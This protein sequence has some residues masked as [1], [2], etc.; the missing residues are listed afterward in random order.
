VRV[1]AA[2]LGRDAGGVGPQAMPSCGARAFGRWEGVKKP[3]ARRSFL[4]WRKAGHTRAHTATNIR[5][6]IHTRARAR[7]R[8]HARA[9]ART[10]AQSAHDHTHAAT[11]FEHH[12]ECR[13]GGGGPAPPHPE[14]RVVGGAPLLVHQAQ[15]LE[16]A[17]LGG[18]ERR[19]RGVRARG[20][21]P[22]ADPYR[23]PMPSPPPLAQTLSPLPALP[24]C[25]CSPAPRPLEKGSPPSVPAPPPHPP[26]RAW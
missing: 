5:G 24:N 6:Q 4:G 20:R 15:P 19:G 8:A 16:A 14:E 10:H 7:A 22:R 23:G 21:P 9:H 11:R 1:R 26:K 2:R 25:P 3:H 12:D 13:G 18:R 17:L